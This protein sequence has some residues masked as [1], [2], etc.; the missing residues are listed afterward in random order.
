MYN[1]KYTN[2]PALRNCYVHGSNR[3]LGNEETHKR[4]YFRLLI[5]MILELLKIED[6]LKLRIP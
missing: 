5:L 2:G 6:D 4:A 1:S 3:S